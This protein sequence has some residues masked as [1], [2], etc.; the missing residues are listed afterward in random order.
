MKHLFVPY[1]LALLA[2]RKEFNEPCLGFY[3]KT[4]NEF[5]LCLADIYN[6]HEREFI[7]SEWLSRSFSDCAAPLYQQIVDWFREEKG[8]LIEITHLLFNKTNTKYQFEIYSKEHDLR[9][10][11]SYVHAFYNEALN[12]AIEEAF[13]L[14]PEL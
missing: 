8:I 1:E 11:G 7:N 9:M 4:H 3:Q 10:Y 6:P 5:E 13:K 14:I 2:K 12:K